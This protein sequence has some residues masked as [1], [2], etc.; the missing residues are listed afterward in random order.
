M[1]YFNKFNDELHLLLNPKPFLITIGIIYEAPFITF[2]VWV[3]PYCSRV[4]L[5]LILQM[6]YHRQSVILHL[7][8]I[9]WG[10]L[11]FCR[12]TLRCIKI[13]TTI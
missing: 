13:E 9:G 8:L 11:F 2:R 10:K 4:A 12:R 7:V 1:R 3:L 5:N 6:K